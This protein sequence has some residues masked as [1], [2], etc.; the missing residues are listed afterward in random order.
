MVSM[1]MNESGEPRYFPNGI[2]ADTGLSVATNNS[3]EAAAQALVAFPPGP[4]ETAS[5]YE[6]AA[7]HK[8]S[9]LGTVQGVIAQDLK[10]AG[11]SILFSS[12]TPNWVKD[13][14]KTLIDFRREQTGGLC[15]VFDGPNAYKKGQSCS[16][17][18][19]EQ[20][21]SLRPVDPHSGV[22]YY[23][24]IIGS[25]EE[26]PFE[27][28]YLL[29]TH[30]GVGRLHFVREGDYLSYSQ[31]VKRYES[32]G[33][34]NERSV[35]FFA[36]SHESDPATNLFCD[37][38][39][40]ELARGGAGRPP[41][42]S[43][44]GYS[45]REFFAESATKKALCG[46]LSG[47]PNS[48]V[49]SLLITGSHGMAFKDNQSIEAKQGAILC[50]DWLGWG[51]PPGPD[52]WFE[53]NDLDEKACFDGLVW[54]LFAC[55]GGGSPQFTDFPSCASK[56]ERVAPRDMLSKLPQS[57]LSHKGGGALAILAH[58]DKAWAYSFHSRG[59]GIQLQSFRD[60]FEG[61]LA[62]RRIG[63]ACDQFDYSRAVLSMEFLETM[64]SK[65]FGKKISDQDLANLWIAR[66][67]A[68]NY[69][70]IGDP[71]VRLLSDLVPGT[72]DGGKGADQE[73]PRM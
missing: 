7:T 11:W 16:E 22:P 28:Q 56:S 51:S 37:R 30:W 33:S 49:P 31:S 60:V 44:A 24:L 10:Q 42:G 69:I 36:T 64:Q 2:Y 15:K 8:Q 62:G 39:A 70:V 45:V 50:Q 14:L 12:S 68:R 71:A 72:L 59:A 38:V 4:A 13:E 32:T 57:I 48:S 19:A 5:N 23:V 55:Y 35:A 63:F 53:A 46:L 25:P 21:V 17:W 29:D 18:L 52:D 43:A 34:R 27:F 41:I 61:I 65:S 47:P 6:K 58:I 1:D 20:G 67:D 73:L 9:R 54:F 26:I 3:A 66:N 40:K